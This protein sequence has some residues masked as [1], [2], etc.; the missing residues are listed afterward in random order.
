VDLN[1]QKTQR[2]AL[3]YCESAKQLGVR[4]VGLSHSLL[5]TKWN[6]IMNL[7]N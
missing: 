3:Q 6:K 2:K 7:N 4:L 1:K 5:G